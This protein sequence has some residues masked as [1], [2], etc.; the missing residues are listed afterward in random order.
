MKKTVYYELNEVRINVNEDVVE[1]YGIDCKEK[2]RKVASVCDISTD[3]KAVER[4]AELCNELDL[5]P[6][7]LEEVAEDWI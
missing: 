2:G 6:A 4:L 5:D 7:Q 1:S 3:R